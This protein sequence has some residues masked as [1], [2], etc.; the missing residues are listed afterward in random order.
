MCYLA[1]H[2]AE[3]AVREVQ[4]VCGIS[5][6]EKTTREKNSNNKQRTAARTSEM[7]KCS[8]HCAPCNQPRK[9]QLFKSAAHWERAKNL[10]TA[11]CTLALNSFAK[12]EM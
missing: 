6:V 1:V 9:K 7:C 5:Q 8:E 4:C 10:H 2:S 12:Q 11:L 3:V